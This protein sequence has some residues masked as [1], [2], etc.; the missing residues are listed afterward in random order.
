MTQPGH[1]PYRSQHSSTCL[2]RF[3]LSQPLVSNPQTS[4]TWKGRDINPTPHPLPIYT[5]RKVEQCGSYYLISIP[6]SQRHFKDPRRLVAF[7]VLA[8]TPQWHLGSTWERKG[9]SLLHNDTQRTDIAQRDGEEDQ[10][11]FPLPPLVFIM[12]R[13]FPCVRLFFAVWRC[14]GERVF[15]PCRD[16]TSVRRWPSGGTRCVLF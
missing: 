15:C 11:S 3:L 13:L 6:Y 8:L 7:M 1:D 9:R 4:K 14:Q 16:C 2:Y 10:F 12:H 5:G